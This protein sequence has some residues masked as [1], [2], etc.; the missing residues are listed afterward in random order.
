[1]HRCNDRRRKTTPYQ[2]RAILTALPNIFAFIK[3]RD[4]TID[5]ISD[6]RPVRN[7][8]KRQRLRCQWR[9][10]PQRDDRRHH[11]SVIARCVSRSEHPSISAGG[12]RRS[13][14]FP[15]G[16][17]PRHARHCLV[18]RRWRGG[19]AIDIRGRP[20]HF[21]RLADVLRHHQRGFDGNTD[22]SVPTKSVYEGQPLPG[23]L[24]RSWCRAVTRPQLQDRRRGLSFAQRCYGRSV[25]AG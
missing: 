23:R 1:M 22:S 13:R 7:H 15:E 24:A 6:S 16:T 21:P 5:S 25:R 8:P 18:R 19:L 3:A 12:W 4:H 11:V 10:Y 9:S 17:L 20:S 2:F 14:L